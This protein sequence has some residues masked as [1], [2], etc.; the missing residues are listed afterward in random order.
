M[1]KPVL[2]VKAGG[3]LY[4]VERT[5]LDESKITKGQEYFDGKGNIRIWGTGHVYSLD[6][7]MIVA[8]PD[9]I[10]IIEESRENNATCLRDMIESDFRI[11]LERRQGECWVEV[12]GLPHT[13]GVSRP[14]YY[15][16][17]V[18]IHIN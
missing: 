5:K 3:Q 13:D 2:L 4:L 8:T 14:I 7:K 1:R 10:G 9:Q 6:S 16:H 17:K 12:D 15:Q 11:I 18:L